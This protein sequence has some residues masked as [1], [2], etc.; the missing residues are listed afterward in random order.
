[1]TKWA[2][3]REP[4][5]VLQRACPTTPPMPIGGQ[6]GR[7]RIFPKSSVLFCTVRSETDPWRGDEGDGE[8]G[9]DSHYYFHNCLRVAH[10][11]NKRIAGKMKR[12][13]TKWRSVCGILVK[14]SAVKSSLAIDNA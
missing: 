8:G 5:V 2:E 4:Q 1:M 11:V 12:E 3:L 9:T 14:Y 7:T 13:K 10:N 6:T